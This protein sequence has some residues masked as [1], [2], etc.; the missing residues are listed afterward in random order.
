MTAD[1]K[2]VRRT[3]AVRAIAGLGGIA[4]ALGLPT[5]VVRPT[6]AVDFAPPAHRRVTAP[7]PDLAAVARLARVPVDAIALALALGVT[8]AAGARFTLGNGLV[9]GAVVH[10]PVANLRSVARVL[11]FSAYGPRQRNASLGAASDALLADDDPFEARAGAGAVVPHARYADPVC[12]PLAVP[13]VDVGTAA[14]GA[15]RPVGHRR[16]TDGRGRWVGIEEQPAPR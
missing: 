13:A 14:P 2:F 11:R 16:I 10:E 6:Y 1:L 8:Y 3:G 15:G 12:T 4:E 7:L 9:L 5:L